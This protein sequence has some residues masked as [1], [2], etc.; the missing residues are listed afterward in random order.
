LFQAFITFIFVC[1]AWV[2]FRAASVSESFIIFS[3]FALLP[4]EFVQYVAQLP[5]NGIVGTVRLMFQLGPEVANPIA[6][7]GMTAFA[8]SVVLIIVLGTVE[9]LTRKT[10]G[11]IQIMKAPLVVRWLLYYGLIIVIFY[12]FSQTGVQFI[13][14]TF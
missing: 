3:K 7:F 5:R 13:Y 2:F 14:F 9:T 8:V 6:A 11:T 12:S 4:M 10:D 1:L